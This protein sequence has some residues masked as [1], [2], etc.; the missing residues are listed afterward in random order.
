[1]YQLNSTVL[2][3]ILSNRIPLHLQTGKAS[4]PEAAI[5]DPRGDRSGGGGLGGAAGAD[6]AQGDQGAHRRGQEEEEKQVGAQHS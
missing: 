4:E 6:G 2:V 5:I 1:M 3:F